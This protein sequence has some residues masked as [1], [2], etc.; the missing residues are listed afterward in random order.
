M[1]TSIKLTLYIT[2]PVP[3]GDFF[4]DEDNISDKFY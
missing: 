1:E 3:A 4:A 2:S